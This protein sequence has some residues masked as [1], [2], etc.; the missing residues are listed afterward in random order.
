MLLIDAYLP[1]TY[2]FNAVKYAAYRHNIMPTRSL[3]SSNTP[4]EARS[5]SKL[6]VSLASRLWLQSLQINIS[7]IGQFPP[8]ARC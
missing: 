7:D 3:G 5:G 6:D 1:N 4:E 2:R 8:Y